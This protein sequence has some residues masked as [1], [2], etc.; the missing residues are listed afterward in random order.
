[1]MGGI[2]AAIKALIDPVRMALYDFEEE[3][4]RAAL[5][6]A[7]HPDERGN[8]IEVEVFTRLREFNTARSPAR[9]QV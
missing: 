6:H 2:Q 5:L 1:M 8:R 4:A 3:C 7:F 9:Y